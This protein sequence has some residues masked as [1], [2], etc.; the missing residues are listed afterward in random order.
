VKKAFDVY[1]SGELLEGYELDKVKKAVGET[2]GISG[3]RLEALFSGVPVRVKK[4]LGVDKAGRFRK[5]FL[6]LGALVQIV[7]AG[8]EP[9]TRSSTVTPAPSTRTPAAPPSPAAAGSRLQLAPQEPLK[10]ESVDRST[11]MP[12]LNRLSLAPLEENQERE[13]ASRKELPPLPDT[14]HLQA[15]PPETGTLEDCAP[16]RKPAPIPDTSGLSLEE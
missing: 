8:E 6:E 7:P 5:A 12:D 16:E 3:P 1:F 11:P 13:A 9:E 15:L 14:S 2:F 10:E 4:N